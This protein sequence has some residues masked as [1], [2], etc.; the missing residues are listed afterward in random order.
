MRS[1]SSRRTGVGRGEEVVC[2][3][4]EKVALR[5]RSRI[6]SRLLAVVVLALSFFGVLFSERQVAS[7]KGEAAGGLQLVAGE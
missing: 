3:E 4:A 7:D 1:L 5:N 2:L 6:L